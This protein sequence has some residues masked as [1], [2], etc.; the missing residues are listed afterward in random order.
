MYYLKCTGC[1][2]TGTPHYTGSTVDFK[3]RWRA[4]KS[5][6]TRLVGK[7][8]NFCEHWSRHHRANPRDLSGVEIYFVDSVKN[9]GS[10]DD[11]YPQLRKLEE[12]WMVD[13]GSLA[14][15]DPLQGCNKRDDAA[16][17]AWGT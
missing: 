17:R 3:A 14:T 13:L 7:C 2:Y 5:D 6:M 1:T 10:R 15:L 11:G 4:H 9:P 8:C 16:A 12:R